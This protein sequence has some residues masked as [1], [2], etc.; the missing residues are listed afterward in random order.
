MPKER[1][2]FLR[3]SKTKELPDFFLCMERSKPRGKIPVTFFLCELPLTTAECHRCRWQRHHV[4][5]ALLTLMF[6]YCSP[7]NSEGKGWQEPSSQ[8]LCSE[9]T[10]C[11][12]TSIPSH[13]H[14]LQSRSIDFIQCLGIICKVLWA[15]PTETTSEV[16]NII[17]LPFGGRWLQK[18]MV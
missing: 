10:G 18:S 15:P 6:S 1:G 4:L 14:P 16:H 11:L 8:Q 5:S 2:I 12:W 13:S 3:T 7:V 17:G 9:I